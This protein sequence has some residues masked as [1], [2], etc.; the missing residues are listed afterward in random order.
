MTATL[1]T[2]PAQ[3]PARVAFGARGRPPLTGRA[4]ERRLL[5]WLLPVVLLGIYATSRSPGVVQPSLADAARAF[6]VVYGACVALHVLF[7]LARFD[8]DPLLLP[9]L[10]LLFLLGT[11][12]HLGMLRPGGGS[13]AGIY[14]TTVV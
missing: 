8:G 2:A 12:Y 11:A 3:T 7:S 13:G 10:T 14:L 4:L 1:P 6:A 5:F 9:L